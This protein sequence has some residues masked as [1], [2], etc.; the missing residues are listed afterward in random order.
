MLRTDRFKYVVFNGGERPEQFFDLQLDPGEVRNLIG[1]TEAANELD[2][3]REL[4]SGWIARIRDDFRIP[5][6]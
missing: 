2:R 1:D 4:L 6:S 5:A 3:H